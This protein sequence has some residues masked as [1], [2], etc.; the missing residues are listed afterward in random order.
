MGAA[1]GILGGD[2]IIS[3]APQAPY[4]GTWAGSSLGYTGLVSD[5]AIDVDFLNIQFY[6][7]GSGLYTTYD[8]LMVET[9]GWISETAVGEMVAN[10]VP[11]AKIVIGKPIAAAGYANNGYVEPAQLNGYAC[12]YRSDSGVEIGGFMTWM[13]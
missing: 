5:G 10:G 8:N 2:K 11:G 3:H 12:T 1:R 4:L 9:S 6:N 13:Y 7:Q